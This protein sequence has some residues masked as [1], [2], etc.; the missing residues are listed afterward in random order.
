MFTAIAIALTS[1]V[2]I[3]PVLVKV[4]ELRSDARPDQWRLD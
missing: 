3:A 1:T 2:V 4:S